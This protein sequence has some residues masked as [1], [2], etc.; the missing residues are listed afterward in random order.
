MT[1]SLFRAVLTS[2]WRRRETTI[3]L[4][5]ACYPL[6]YLVASFFGSSNFMQIQ[7][8]D[9]VKIGYLDFADM[10]LNSLD[11]MLLPTVALYFLTISVFK[12]EISDHTLFLYKDINRRSIFLAKLL[13]LVC[14]LATYFV[15]FIGVSLLVHY[16]RV[17]QM[18]FGSSRFWAEDGYNTVYELLNMVSIFFKGILSIAVGA[19]LSLRFGTGAT[20][21]VAIGLSLVMTVTGIIGGPVAL[22][23]PTGYPSLLV[24]GSTPWLPLLGAVGVTSAYS[25]LCY[26]FGLKTFEQMEF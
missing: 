3:Y 26:V 1:S 16:S 24:V 17:V 5:F 9:G 25:L 11:A 22:L 8:A 19:L 7:V 21:G 2:V 4:A 14:V 23:F 13:S 15:V 12:R 18:D 6:I 10:M 20:L